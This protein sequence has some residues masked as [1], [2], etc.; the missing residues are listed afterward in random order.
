MFGRKLK[1]IKLGETVLYDNGHL[2]VPMTLCL[3][4]QEGQRPHLTLC[5]PRRKA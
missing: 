2:K 5:Q 3:I 4:E 1:T